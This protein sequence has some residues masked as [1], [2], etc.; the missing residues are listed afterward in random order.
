[1]MQEVFEDEDVMDSDVDENA[2]SMTALSEGT[3]LGSESDSGNEGL[4]L[5]D[6]MRRLLQLQQ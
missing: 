6:A 3:E 5:K 4:T 2:T 1:M